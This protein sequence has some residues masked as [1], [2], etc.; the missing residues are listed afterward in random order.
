M[1][2]RAW[3]HWI[4]TLKENPIY[5]REAGRI[6]EPNPF[7]GTIRRYM[8]FVVI[9]AIFLGICGGS[10]NQSFLLNQSDEFFAIWCLVCI[11]GMLLS[12]VTIFGSLMAPAITAPSISMELD[13]GS[14][15]LLRVVPQSTGA[16]LLAKLLGGLARLRI[17]W[18]LLILSLFQGVVFMFSTFMAVEELRIWSAFLGLTAVFRPWLEILFAAFTGMF[19]STWVRSAPTALIGSYGIILGFR[20]LNTSL[21]WF[22]VVTSLG[23]NETAAFGLSTAGPI[24][25]YTLSL[26][27]MAWGIYKRAETYG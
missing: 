14:W 1:S 23:V 11:P 13:R 19:V 3:W 8:P 7:Y 24:L 2:L 18:I 5:L 16:I 15:D 10:T 4:R 25:M 27:I 17:W 22:L 6:G 21:A 12:M 26:P 9:G 20:L